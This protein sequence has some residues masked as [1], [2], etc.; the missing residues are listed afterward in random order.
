MK[1][2]FL[3]LILIIGLLLGCPNNEVKSFEVTFDSNGGSGSMGALTVKEGYSVKLSKNK[4]TKNGYSFLGWSKNK[5][6]TTPTYSDEATVEKVSESFTLYAVWKMDEVVPTVYNL[7]YS[8]SS[9]ASLKSGAS[10]F[11]DVE[12][13]VGS[14]VNLPNKVSFEAKYDV[15]LGKLFKGWSLIEGSDEVISI[16]T[17]SEEPSEDVVLYA[18][19]A[20]VYYASFNSN[21]GSGDM[22]NSDGYEVGVTFNLPSVSFTAPSGQQ[23]KEW[24]LSSDG[25]GVSYSVGSEYTFV[26]SDVTFYAIWEAAGA[27]YH[28]SYNVNSSGASLKGGQTAFDDVELSENLSITLP[29][30]LEFFAKY[31][32][33]AKKVF[34]GWG[35]TSNATTFISEYTVAGSATSDVVIYAIFADIYDV[36]FDSNSGSGTMDSVTGNEEGGVYILPDCG[37]TAP[38]GKEFAS[39]NTADDGNGIPYA[40][41]S[42]YTFATSDV[43]FYAIWSDITYTASFDKNEGSGTVSSMTGKYGDSITLPDCGFTA[44]IGKEFVSW[45]TASDGNGDS[46]A[47]GVSYTFTASNVTFY[48]IWGDATYTA[49]FD[50]NGG[51]GSVLSKTGKY[52]ETI[53]LPDC[54]F[55]APTGKEFDSWN[56]ASDG[57]G[58]TFAVGSEYT[59]ADLDV[60]FYAI[61]SDIPYSASFD[62]N[63]GSGTVSSMTG[64][65]GGSITLPDCGFTAPTGKEFVSWNTASDGNGDSYIAGASYTFEASNVTFYAIWGDATYTA[66][67]DKNGGSGTVS[68]MTG[69][70]GESI[71]LPDCG[72]TAPTGKEFASWNTV[73]DGSGDSYAVGEGYTFATS[74]VTFYAIWGDAIYS[75]SFDNNGGSGTVSSMTGKYGD[76]INLPDCEF[77]APTGK[78]FASW[79][80]ASDG[81]GDSY[82][83]G[84][85]YTFGASNVTF[86]AI[87]SNVT[88]T[89]SFNENGG[90]G[91]ISSMTGE[92]GD[93]IT[94]P[95]CSFTAPTGK[96]FASWNTADDGNGDSYAEGVSYTFTASN[97]TFYAIWSDIPYSA[98]FDS[99]GG[100]GTVSSI[101]GVYGGSITL[102]DC[103]FTAQIGKEFVS[104]N[105]V[106]DGSGDSYIAGASY[107]FEASDVTFYAIWGDATYTASFDSNGGSGSMLSMTGKYG[108]SITLPDCSLLNPAGKEFASWN[109]ASDGN[110]TTLAVGDSYTFEASD[111]TFYAIWSSIPTEFNITGEDVMKYVPVPALGITFPRGQNNDS[112]GTVD[113]HYYV[114]ATETTYKLWNVVKTWADS[115]SYTFDNVG[116]QGGASNTGDDAIGN[117]LNPVTK[118][119]WKDAIVWC[120]ALTE[121][122]NANNGSDP[123]LA[124]V[125]YSDSSFSTP[126]KR[127]SDISSGSDVNVNGSADGYRLPSYEEWECAA[128]WQGTTNTNDNYVTSNPDGCTSGYFWTKGDSASGSI[129]NSN[130]DTNAVAVSSSNA[131]YSSSWG[132]KTYYTVAVKSKSA[133]A[134]GLSD[135]NGNVSEYLITMDGANAYSVGGTFYDYWYDCHLHNARSYDISQSYDNLI[136]GTYVN[137]LGFRVVKNR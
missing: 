95:S 33:A 71:T 8:V 81:N 45:N 6:A 11:D 21:G 53:T 18:V 132:S 74:D 54:E 89:A 85:S 26:D 52:L 38:I 56:T 110:G 32:L 117:D 25:N 41:S 46:Y 84:A 48:A 86:Y 98:S 93:S 79:N 99:N 65:Y 27:A 55:T 91:T 69:A 40:V 70:Y 13:Q 100:S 105:T 102:P 62:K 59:F 124:M 123:D 133:N 94:L 128:R 82:V 19:F 78:E 109:T 60:T 29:T 80:T 111:V 24:N 90:S 7:S 58:N 121:Y 77:T 97:V 14:P 103:E 12:L 129:S 115:H 127:T 30:E 42:E 22:S 76:S 72:F 135:M 51:S 92:Y 10:A 122:Y 130:S 44:P 9:D 63:G 36:V 34:K 39:W 49:S 106:S 68:S 64:K 57:N 131:P 114:A 67:F 61:W 37:F 83:V 120:N 108:E 126:L 23:F 96:Q 2:R 31:D 15:V 134:L 3:F 136:Y 73:S 116:R 101:A 28:L 75:A 125:Y 119:N 4:F 50:K 112:T 113:S 137:T 47:E 66:A 16:Y 20:D 118:I 87:W 17:V 5:S 43:T 1:K 88:Y 35:A 104:W 107:T